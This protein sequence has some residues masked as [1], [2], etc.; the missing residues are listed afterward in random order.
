MKYKPSDLIAIPVLR[1]VGDKADRFLAPRV[2]EDR[3]GNKSLASPLEAMVQFYLHKEEHNWGW[4]VAIRVDGPHDSGILRAEV[5]TFA[6]VERKGGG[7]H[8]DVLGVALAKMGARLNRLARIPMSDEKTS[9]QERL[10]GAHIRD[11]TEW[12]HTADAAVHPVHA[13]LYRDRPAEPMYELL[14]MSVTTAAHE[15]TDAE[16]LER[17]GLVDPRLPPKPLILL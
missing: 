6:R 2:I 16:K 11:A 10:I 13:G 4:G 5:L 15:E 9:I 3:E 12:L 1:I 8:A 14:D 17:L 7:Q